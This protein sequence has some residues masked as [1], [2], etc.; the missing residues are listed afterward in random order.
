MTNPY[1][2]DDAGHVGDEEH[3]EQANDRV[4]RGVRQPGLR[5]VGYQGVHMRQ[6]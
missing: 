5:R 2:C 4:E 1:D 6:S 3:P